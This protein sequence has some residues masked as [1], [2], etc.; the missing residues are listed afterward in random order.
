[1]EQTGHFSSS[2]LAKKCKITPDGRSADARTDPLL[3]Q[4]GHMFVDKLVFFDPCQGYDRTKGILCGVI[5][6]REA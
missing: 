5:S 3:P 2:G 4:V 6:Q 1:M